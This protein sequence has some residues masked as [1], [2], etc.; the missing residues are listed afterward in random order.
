MALQSSGPISLN[1][2]AG[3]F[4]GS[5]P[6]SLSE[7]YGVASGVPG[8]GTISLSN[9][10][11]KSAAVDPGPD[12]DPDPPSLIFRTTGFGGGIG[13]ADYD[14]TPS[15]GGTS[16]TSVYAMAQNNGNT[17][18]VNS[19]GVFTEGIGRLSGVPTG[20]GSNVFSRILMFPKTSGATWSPLPYTVITIGISGAGLVDS[21]W[22][23]YDPIWSRYTPPGQSGFSNIYYLS[24]ASSVQPIFGVASNG[25]SVGVI[26]QYMAQAM[27]SGNAGLGID[28]LG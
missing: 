10:Y 18:G 12:P 13:S 11:G 16:Y 21:G 17:G 20:L 22:K 9:F 15:F 14:S 19:A 5:T 3:E 6:H 2:V 24:S 7:Y 1:N 23:V 27:D 26:G 25:D 28:F 8:S 4:G